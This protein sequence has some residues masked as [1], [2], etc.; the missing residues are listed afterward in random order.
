[1]LFVAA[2]AFHVAKPADLIPELQGRF[3]I[4]VELEPLG[5][6]EL[7]RILTEPR[8]AL[9][10]QY[11]QLLGAD[12]LDLSWDAEAVA[13]IARCAVEV[14]AQA[15][16][17]GARRLATLLEALLEE[18]AFAAPERGGRLRLDAELVRQKLQPLVRDQ[19]LARFIL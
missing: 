16:N 5:L 13:E 1:M 17:I 19:D 14:N 9:L 3:P 11:R 10:E 2:G 18:A 4:R 6:E 7:R 15:E 8:G 12:G